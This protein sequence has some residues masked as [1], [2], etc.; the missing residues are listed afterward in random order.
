MGVRL[1]GN[2]FFGTTHTPHRL[3]IARLICI[4]NLIFL[5][6]LDSTESPGHRVLGKLAV[7]SLLRTFFSGD[8]VAFWNTA[9]PFFRV[10][11]RGL[12][13]VE[14]PA[15]ESATSNPRSFIAEAWKWKYRVSEMLQAAAYDK[16]LYLDADCMAL[17]NIDHLLEGEWDVA[18]QPQRHPGHFSVFS[19]HLSENEMAEIRKAPH[20]RE[21][22]GINAGSFAI[23]GSIFR[24]VMAEYERIDNRELRQ[25]SRFGEQGAWNRLVRDI[26]AGVTS[27]GIPLAEPLRGLRVRP[28]EAGE[29]LFPIEHDTNYL[30]YKDAAIVHALGLS[31]RDKMRFLFGLYMGTFFHD[32][33]GTLLDVLET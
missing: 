7:A 11:R 30:V 8:I 14:L 31:L 24:E 15:V 13:E 19:A 9:A 16:V 22:L 17:R 2:S 10:E 4:M 5:L 32:D 12:T 27:Q 26:K 1:P 21:N 6:A 25:P 20:A 33:H 3:A 18:Y 23:R 28:F 29:I